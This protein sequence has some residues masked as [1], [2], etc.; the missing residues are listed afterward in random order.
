[1]FSRYFRW[2]RDR[3][4]VVVAVLAVLWLGVLNG[5]LVAVAISVAMALR[6]FA[7]DRVAELGR[8]HGT[9]DFV[10]ILRH[11]EAE[12]VPGVLIL[13]PAAPVF[14]ANVDRILG[15]VNARHASATARTVVLSLEETPDLDGTAIEALGV[16]AADIAQRGGTLLLARLKPPILDGLALAALPALDVRYVSFYSVDDAVRSSQPEP[17]TTT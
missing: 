8:L 2:Q 7:T 9:H 11:P 3:L 13:R 1:V 4:L 15:Q 6:G 16:L 17:A 10:D 5:L 14:F 12:H